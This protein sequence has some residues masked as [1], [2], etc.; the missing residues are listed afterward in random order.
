MD[1]EPVALRFG[2]DCADGGVW[3][4]TAGPPASLLAHGAIGGACWGSWPAP[5]SLP[6][7]PGKIWFG[8]FGGVSLPHPGALMG[9]MAMITFPWM[10]AVGYSH[11]FG[12]VVHPGL[13]AQQQRVEAAN[14]P[15]SEVAPEDFRRWVITYSKIETSDPDVKAE[16][17][18][19]KPG[20]TNCSLMRLGMVIETASLDGAWGYV[21]D[22]QVVADR[23]GLWGSEAYHAAAPPVIVLPEKANSEQQATAKL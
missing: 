20:F 23:L 2:W 9:V 8:A 11:Y 14:A 5:F 6:E 17:A 4:G 21:K 7:R 1:G 15:K 13:M 16:L 3:K 10:T 19:L 18:R 22:P 12:Y